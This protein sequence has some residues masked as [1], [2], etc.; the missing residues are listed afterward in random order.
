[1]KTLR[2]LL[3]TMGFTASL[4]G[5][6]IAAEP[7]EDLTSQKILAE[8]ALAH[9]LVAMG[10]GDA[11]GAKDY[12]SP[13]AL[14]IAAGMLNR[15][16]AALGGKFGAID[17]APTDADGKPLDAKAEKAASLK[18]EAEGL[19]IEAQGMLPK[20][21]AARASALKAM[22]DREMKE[23]ERGSI[24]GPKRVTFTLAPGATHNY[25][26]N[27][28]SGQQAG[29]AMTSTGPPKIHFSITHANGGN[30]FTLKGHNATYTWVPV[31]DPNNVRH[32]KI[33]LYNMGNKP[34]TYTL[35][36]N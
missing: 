11:I 2:L 22:I 31:R 15:A 1:M 33:S 18:D 30:L 16:H 12:K 14:V 17:A 6:A 5:S 32:F 34:T 4:T 23:P 10:R 19:I 29:V 9:D 28:V 35:I 8:I 20:G 25:G 36:T 13:E 7:A 3:L 27:F 21:D 24:T 26:I